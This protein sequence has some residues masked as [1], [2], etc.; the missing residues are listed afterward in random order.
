MNASADKDPP[1]LGLLIKLM[2]LTAS[3]NDSEA[4]LAIRKA[5]EQLQ[6]FGGDWERLLQGRVTVIGDPFG[7]I[8]VPFNEP[9]PRY[10]G[11][12]APQ[13][14]PQPPPYT[15][16]ESMRR[17]KQAA[18]DAQ[19]QRQQ[20]AAAKK[21]SRQQTANDLSLDDLDIRI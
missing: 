4:L 16:A 6:K 18:A 21:A 12:S 10:D 9:K 2:K 5:N 19:R 8:P 15:T 20:R 14:A 17:Q 13:A 7:Q 3:T 11:Y 1:N